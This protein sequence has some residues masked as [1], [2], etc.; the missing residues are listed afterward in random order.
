LVIT[1]YFVSRQVSEVADSRR[2]ALFDTT[3]GR[4][5]DLDKLFVDHPDARPYF[6]E[7]ATLPSD[8][9]EKQ[10]ILAIAELH[11]DYFDT[12]LLKRATFPSVLSQFPSFEPWIRALFNSSP[13]MC[14]IMI[15]DLD[16]GEK[17]WY[18]K[19]HSIYRETV[20]DGTA[21]LPPPPSHH[22]IA[23]PTWVSAAVTA[24]IVIAIVG[25]NAAAGWFRNGR[26]HVKEI[27]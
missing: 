7:G 15:D 8:P 4:M 1:G 17:M 24:T 12:D 13:A 23:R 26:G 3:A 16:R 11:I 21:A 5:L 22:N 14:Q 9:N 2:G 19:I 10:L 18:D 27:T 6:Y 20:S 25:K